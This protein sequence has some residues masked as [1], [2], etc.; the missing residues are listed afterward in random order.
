MG[1]GVAKILSILLRE[2]GLFWRKDAGTNWIQ[3]SL[4]REMIAESFWSFYLDEKWSGFCKWS[5]FWIVILSYYVYW[6]N[7]HAKDGP[8][9]CYGHFCPPFRQ[10]VT[11]T[12]LYP[13]VRLS[14]TFFLEKNY[15]WTDF[16]DSWQTNINFFFKFIWSSDGS[17][18]TNY[19]IP[20]SSLLPGIKGL[21]PS[22][23]KHFI[24]FW[25]SIY[26]IVQSNPHVP[27]LRNIFSLRV[28]AVS[29]IVNFTKTEKLTWLLHWMSLMH[30]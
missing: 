24:I 7:Q 4:K 29:E 28:S 2:S 6:S 1:K 26:P 13:Q 18:C 11:L 25:M 8:S 20:P 14:C 10:G 17:V 19:K 16:D 22:F 23:K 12:H 5:W 30:L 27:G 21:I 15:N 9:F 3:S